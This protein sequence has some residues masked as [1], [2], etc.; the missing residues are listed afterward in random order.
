MDRIISKMGHYKRKYGCDHR[1]VFATTYQELSKEL[2]RSLRHDQARW[3]YRRYLYTEAAEFANYYFRTLRRWERGAPVPPA[4]Q[5]VLETARDKSVLGAQDML[6]GINAHV[7][8]DMPFVIA[9]LGL[10]DRKGRSRKADHD[11][12]NQVLNDSYERVVSAVGTRFDPSLSLTNSDL[13]PLDDLGG[14]EM[15]RVWREGVWRNA[16]RLVNATSD[17]ER[18]SVGNSILAYAAGWANGIATLETPGYRTRR[19]SYCAERLGGRS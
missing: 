1:G 16:E 2:R 8:S 13:T 6:L 4:W 19:D 18:E 15:V 7:Q 14:L 12:M 3:Q 17:A 11:Y 9:S 10:R 5:V